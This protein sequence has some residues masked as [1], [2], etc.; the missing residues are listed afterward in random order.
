MSSACKNFRARLERALRGR[1][2]AAE[3]SGLAWHEHLLACVPCRELLQAEEALEELLAS[4]PEPRLPAHLAE[5]VLAR[6]A[7]ERRSDAGD[8][9]ELLELDTAPEAPAGLV[10][11]VLEGLAAERRVLGEDAALDRLL[12]RV[13]APQAPEGLSARV[14]AGLAAERGVARTRFGSRVERYAAAAVVLLAVGFLAW[15]AG[16]PH[17][18]PYSSGPTGLTVQ[19][20]G[21]FVTDAE[22]PSDELLAVLDVL[23]NWKLVASEEVDIALATLDPADEELYDILLE[24]SMEEEG[25]EG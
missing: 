5:R 9:D 1:G 12:E 10:G 13:P 15:L 17:P 4:L 21:S 8:L 6:L 16:R 25:D 19:P 7:A 22:E 23:E 11:R 18:T 3:R 14:L 24:S 2:D 20:A